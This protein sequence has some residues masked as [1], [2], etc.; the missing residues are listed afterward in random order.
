MAE[1]ADPAVAG[2][3]LVPLGV[4]MPLG[5]VCAV[6][7]ELEAFLGLEERYFGTPLLRDV[8]ADAAV[9]E[10]A[11]FFAQLALAGDDMGLARPALVAAGDLEV[12]KRQPLL[13]ALGMALERPR[14]HLDARY[15]PEALAVHR[16]RPEERRYPGTA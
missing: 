9:A 4:V 15:L 16:T 5:E 6:Q 3:D 2:E 1:E 8:P 7:R 10:H 12:E 13:H 14:V 11:A